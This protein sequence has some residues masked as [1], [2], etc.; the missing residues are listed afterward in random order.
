MSLTEVRTTRREV[1]IPTITLCE[2]LLGAEQFCRDC[3]MC[4]G[5]G[6]ERGWHGVRIGE[7]VNTIEPCTR[8]Y[9]TRRAC[10][11]ARQAMQRI[12]PPEVDHA[13]PPF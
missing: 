2:V 6:K 1:T 11:E 13:K 4:G 3:H 7:G 10:E 8:C 9:L 12:G 5:T